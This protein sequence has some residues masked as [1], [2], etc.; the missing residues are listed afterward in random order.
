MLVLIFLNLLPVGLLMPATTSL[1]LS[2]FTDESGTASAFMGF[3]F[4]VF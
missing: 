3:I 1:G 2:Y 4:T